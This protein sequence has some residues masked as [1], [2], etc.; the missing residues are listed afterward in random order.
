MPKHSH[1]H[2]DKE[3]QDYEYDHGQQIRGAYSQK[4]AI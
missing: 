3:E 2:K 4:A 1:G